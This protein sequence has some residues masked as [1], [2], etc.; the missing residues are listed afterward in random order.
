MQTSTQAR[1]L[2]S[3][4]MIGERLCPWVLRMC[5]GA[6]ILAL[7]VIGGCNEHD[8]E[9]QTASEPAKEGQTA[10]GRTKAWWPIRVIDEQATC[11]IQVLCGLYN[12]P[13]FPP[14]SITVVWDGR[15]VWADTLPSKGPSWGIPELLGNIWTSPGKHT[16]EVRHGTR[17]QTLSVD[18]KDQQAICVYV[19]GSGPAV[20]RVLIENLGENPGWR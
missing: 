5:C 6:A 11:R 7:V 20:N 8:K 3:D 4:S 13:R 1:S 16:L 17:S 2:T 19:L 14:P 15:E 9:G 12:D 18:L 10:G